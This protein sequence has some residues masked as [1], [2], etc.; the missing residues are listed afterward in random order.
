MDILGQVEGIP[1]HPERA[2]VDQ[3]DHWKDAAAQE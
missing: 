3:L 2:P 1:P